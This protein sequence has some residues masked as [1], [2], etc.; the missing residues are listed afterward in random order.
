[1]TR[2]SNSSPDGTRTTRE[3]TEDDGEELVSSTSEGICFAEVNDGD[4]PMDDTEEISAFLGRRERAESEMSNSTAQSNSESADVEGG[5]STSSASAAL[6]LADN[7]DGPINIAEISATLEQQ[8]RAEKAEAQRINSQTSS[9]AIPPPRRESS[10]SSVFPLAGKVRTVQT[11]LSASAQE[12]TIPRDGLDASARRTFSM[13]SAGL[14]SVPSSIMAEAY[15]VPDSPVFTASIVEITPWYKQRRNMCMLLIMLVVGAVAAV[16]GG[17]V[18]DSNHSTTRANGPTTMLTSQPTMTSVPSSMPSMTNSP[19]AVVCGVTVTQPVILDRSHEC[20]CT[21]SPAVVVKGTGVEFNLNSFTVACMA[22]S[23]PVIVVDG[24]SNSVKGRLR[25][26]TLRGGNGAK[27]GI[28]GSQSTQTRIQ[29][30]GSGNHTVQDLAVR[31]TDTSTVDQI[32]VEIESSGNTV[33]NCNIDSPSLSNATS[34]QVGVQMKGDDNVLSNNYISVRKDGTD[35]GRINDIGARLSASVAQKYGFQNYGIQSFGNN[36]LIIDNTISEGSDGIVLEQG[37]CQVRDNDISEQQDAAIKVTGIIK[38]GITL[39]QSSSSSIFHN[40]IQ[41]SGTAIWCDSTLNITVYDNTL[42]NSKWGMKSED[43]TSLVVSNIT[44]DGMDFI[45]SSSCSISGNWIQN[46]ADKAIALSTLTDVTIE[47]NTLIDCFLGVWNDD[48]TSLAISSSD[49]TVVDNTLVNC[50]WGIYSEDSASLFISDMK[51][52][53]IQLESLTSSSINGNSINNC[54]AISLFESSDV[55]VEDNTLVDSKW[56]IYIENSISLAI[57][58]A[59][60]SSIMGNSIQNCVE[61][62][63]YLLDSSHDVTVKANTLVDSKWGVRSESTTSIVVRD[64]KEDGIELKSSTSSSIS[65][66]SIRSCDNDAINLFDSSNVTIKDNTLANNDWGIYSNDVIS[67]VV[68]NVSLTGIDLTNAASSSIIGNSI[69]NCEGGVLLEG[70]LDTKIVNNTVNGND[71]GGIIITASDEILIAGNMLD[72]NNGPGISLCVEMQEFHFNFEGAYGPGGANNELIDNVITASTN[73]A[74]IHIGEG[75]VATVLKG[76]VAEDGEDNQ[77]LIDNESPTTLISSDNV[78]NFAFTLVGPGHCQDSLSQ[79]Y[80]FATFELDITTLAECEATCGYFDITNNLVGFEVSSLAC[81]CLFENGYLLSEI[82][83]SSGCPDSA[84][85]CSIT[86]TE[87]AAAVIP[88]LLL[89]KGEDPALPPPTRLRRDS[90]RR[91]PPTLARTAR[92]SPSTDLRCRSALVDR[93]PSAV[94][95]SGSDEVADSKSYNAQC[96]AGAVADASP[97]PSMPW[98]RQS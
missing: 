74:Q 98:D 22:G 88:T 67:V 85:V 55:T 57:R 97:W 76:N 72:S 38:Q 80:D 65:G 49:V 6:C 84:S 18:V 82:P 5:A 2:T 77:L 59:A 11:N 56:G 48:A 96:R 87:G 19:T 51:D 36:C 66:N 90:S 30:V 28:V 1:M 64:M 75:C 91:S 95:G 61:S 41:H 46:C 31:L 50:V 23:Q 21:D 39:K 69:I 44:D 37:S 35:N 58:D 12:L 43:A 16:A 45:R 93:P 79:L 47:N 14:E 86:G 8:D 70:G 24:I 78:P 63:I 26:Q 13:E 32:G 20:D 10:A 34:D 83:G 53:G 68:S 94:A 54:E 9:A 15:T 27:G 81:L 7:G 73:A 52:D 25:D 89:A 92:Q 29:L 60:L 3:E 62:A 17:V 71:G 33:D 4:G 42:V 40:T